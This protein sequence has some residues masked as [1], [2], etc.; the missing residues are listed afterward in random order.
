M[1]ISRGKIAGA[2]ECPG[3]L[4]VVST[5]VSGEA[6]SDESGGIV[7]KSVLHLA[8]L[9]ALLGSRCSATAELKT[10]ARTGVPIAALDDSSMYRLPEPGERDPLADVGDEVL[11]KLDVK[12]RMEAMIEKG[13][14][15]IPPPDA[16]WAHIPASSRRY[17]DLDND[18][19]PELFVVSVG[20][21]KWYPYLPEF[22]TILR[23][24][25]DEYNQTLDCWE[26]LSLEAFEQFPAEGSG[27]TMGRLVEFDLA[28]GDIDRDGRP[29][30]LFT[31]AWY[32]G[33]GEAR[34]LTVLSIQRSMKL[35]QERLW[36]REPIRVLEPECLRSVF[37]QFDDDTWTDRDCGASMRGRGYRKAD[38]NWTAEE[39][40]VK[41]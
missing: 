18:G 41:F 21:Q 25:K 29:D 10:N 30:I 11:L 13:G 9:A 22:A 40:F 23:K 33:S 27:V 6:V 8:V 34:Y 39:G 26:L 7:A 31:H 36:S 3:R 28:I 35:R 4:N 12:A 20:L 15:E 17:V 16:F 32:G 24:S 19:T 38:Y 37:V 14:P 2:G 5:V 1:P